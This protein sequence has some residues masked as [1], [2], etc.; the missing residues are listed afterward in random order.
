[1]FG[2]LKSFE[3]CNFVHGKVD[4]GR[5]KVREALYF[6]CNFAVFVTFGSFDGLI[7]LQ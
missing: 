5:Q 1:M 2:R 6:V 4:R 3:K 7:V